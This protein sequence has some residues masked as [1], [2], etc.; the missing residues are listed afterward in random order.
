VG[1]RK[2]AFGFMARMTSRTATPLL[3]EEN[4]V[5]IVTGDGE[6][7]PVSITCHSPASALEQARLLS[8]R[9]VRNILIDAQGQEY[10][11][12]DFDRLFVVPG[13]AEAR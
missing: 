12:A 9:G 5:F 6:N 2:D 3:Q 7:G 11:P 8:D 13:P 1:R 10:A 4:M